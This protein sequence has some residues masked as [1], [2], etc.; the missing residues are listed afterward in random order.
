[1]QE[2]GS[3][4]PEGQGPNDD[5]KAAQAGSSEDAFSDASIG[6]GGGSDAADAGRAEKSSGSAGRQARRTSDPVVGWLGLAIAVVLVIWLAGILS[7]MVFGVIRQ[8]SAPRT[9]TE[10]DLLLAETTVQGGKANTKT[11]ALYIGTLIDAG[12]LSKAQEALDQAIKTTKTDQSYLYE[13]QAQLSLV[14]KDYAGAIAAAD[15]AMDGAK[16]ELKLFM[17][18]NVK[19]NRRASAGAFLP[20][21]YGEA[22]LTKAEAL[23]ATR[24]Y[25]GAIK[26]FDLYLAE[27]PIDADVLV[28]RAATKARVGDNAGA[29]ADYRAALKY[30]PDYQPA[31]DGLK[32]IGASK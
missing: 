18:A 28:K 13:R 22:A 15:K 26:V 31:L 25:A 14:R 16:K 21:S 29:A 10:R 2:S 7:A 32:Q 27:Q 12:Q 19:A 3:D 5:A 20:T 23:L 11:Y 9:S 6:A 24:D 30:I 4:S 8:P 17:D 1:M